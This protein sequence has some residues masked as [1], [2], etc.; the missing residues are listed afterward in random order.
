M[1]TGSF[2]K[3][4]VGIGYEVMWK[5]PMAVLRSANTVSRTST[6]FDEHNAQSPH[7]AEY[8]ERPQ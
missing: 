6:G 8:R 1:E 5:Y 4:D 3:R 2:P 7:K